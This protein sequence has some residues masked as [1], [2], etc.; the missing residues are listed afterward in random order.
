MLMPFDFK[1][2]VMAREAP[3]RRDARPRGA[4]VRQKR[5]VQRECGA[6]ES[7]VVHRLRS[8]AV[9][10]AV[11]QAAAEACYRVCVRFCA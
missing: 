7:R 9:R 4:A 10:R 5:K 2:E 3:T 11:Q 6:Q 8:A 1:S